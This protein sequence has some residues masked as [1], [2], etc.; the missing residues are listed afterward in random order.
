MDLEQRATQ[1]A[2][3]DPMGLIP[4][5]SVL[6]RPA[7]VVVAAAPT[8]RCPVARAVQAAAVPQTLPVPHP[9]GLVVRAKAIL[10][11]MVCTDQQTATER[12][13][14]VAARLPQEQTL[15]METVGQVDLEPSGRLGLETTTQ[16]AAAA[17]V[18]LHRRPE[19]PAEPAAAAREETHHQARTRLQTLEAV[20]AADSLE[21]LPDSAATAARES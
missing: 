21:V 13:E 2:S 11:A 20:A 9:A 19:V 14:A 15:A 10:A 18:A 6:P 16:V 17:A 12:L 7:A 5:H 8:V 1:V 3:K 4:V